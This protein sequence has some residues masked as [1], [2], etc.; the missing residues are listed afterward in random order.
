MALAWQVCLSRYAGELEPHAEQLLLQAQ[1]LVEEQD[2]GFVLNELGFLYG[3]QGRL[4]EATDAQRSTL[5]WYQD[6]FGADHRE[7]LASMINLA[8]TLRA[9]GDLPGARDLQEKVLATT[10]RVLGADHPHTLRNMNNLAL[11]LSA[12]GDVQGA[13]DLQEKVL[14]TRL[15]TLGPRHPAT[16]LV[17]WNMLQ[18]Y[19]S[20]Q[21]Q[22][23]IRDLLPQMQWLL[24][25]DPASLSAQQ[26]RIAQQ[27]P[28]QRGQK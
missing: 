2:T 15:T 1:G 7:T 24:Q 22:T 9:Q 8:E 25:A 18:T 14:E 4:S 13:R 26:L 10:S 27:L 5:Q 23:A 17:Q 21:D 11:T 16:T 3:Y 6:K 20:L 28:Q 12:Q 19:A